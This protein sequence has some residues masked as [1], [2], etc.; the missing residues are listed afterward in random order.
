[1]GCGVAVRSRG[2]L[3]PEEVLPCGWSADRALAH[4]WKGVVGQLRLRPQQV[5][6]WPVERVEPVAA[7][8]GGVD[9]ATVER[10][11]VVGQMTRR[12]RP[13]PALLRADPIVPPSLDHPD[14]TLTVLVLI[15][16]MEQE[17]FQRLGVSVGSNRA[18]LLSRRA[19]A[20]VE[21]CF[22]AHGHVTPHSGEYLAAATLQ[23]QLRQTGG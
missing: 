9:L 15:G 13:S 16:G 6:G 5:L 12:P 10:V 11:G 17:R 21:V 2:V 4:A 8:G 7:P 14:D 23:R 20:N 22:G 3:G 19:A 18:K 1:M